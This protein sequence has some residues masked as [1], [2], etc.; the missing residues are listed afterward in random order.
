RKLN[1]L[2]RSR[3]HEVPCFRR[4]ASR[5]ARK[6]HGCK[7]GTAI[8]G[9]D[10]MDSRWRGSH[11]RIGL[12]DLV[13]VNRAVLRRIVIAPP[14]RATEFTAIRSTDQNTVAA[15]P[16]RALV[17]KRQGKISPWTHQRHFRK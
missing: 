5:T 8:A 12:S 4:R 11:R 9:V 7:P 16:S 14:C 6:Q 10:Q 3:W 2:G 15:K 17:L 13:A 1:K